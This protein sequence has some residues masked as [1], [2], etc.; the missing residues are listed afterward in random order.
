MCRVRTHRRSPAHTSG[1]ADTFGTKL[2]FMPGGE[3]RAAAP[4]QRAL[5]LMVSM[6]HPGIAARALVQW[7]SAPLHSRPARRIYRY[8]AAPWPNRR[9]RT[10]TSSGWDTS[11]GIIFPSFC[12]LSRIFPAALL[13]ENLVHAWL[14][15]V[16]RGMS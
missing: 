2:H 12:V 15:S 13:V 1:L 8:W 9:F 4:A 11:R 10:M 5:G 3:A 6:I 7:P 14:V 16:R